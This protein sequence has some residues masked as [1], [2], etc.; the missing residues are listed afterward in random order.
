MIEWF[1]KIT[2]L[3]NGRNGIWTQFCWFP[4]LQ[5]FHYSQYSRQDRI[6]KFCFPETED[7]VELT[8]EYI[9]WLPMLKGFEGIKNL[10]TLPCTQNIP[11]AKG[12]CIPRES[13][14]SS[15]FFSWQFIAQIRRNCF[16]PGQSKERTK[17]IQF[18][19]RIVNSHGGNRKKIMELWP[20]K[21]IVPVPLLTIY[22][23][24]L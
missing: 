4:K 9:W 18:R 3:I 2:Q 6:V 13:R 17:S 1:F 11:K 24:Q 16:L 7:T 22:F 20:E 23:W 19:G 21:F 14:T 15:F 10:S 5:S 12:Y 8:N